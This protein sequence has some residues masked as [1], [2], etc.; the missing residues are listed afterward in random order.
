M[1]TNSTNNAIIGNLIEQSNNLDPVE[2]AQAKKTEEPFEAFL[3]Y[4]T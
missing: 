2:P 3:G 4:R 1:Y